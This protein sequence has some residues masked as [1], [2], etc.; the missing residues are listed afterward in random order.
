MTGNVFARSEDLV[1]ARRHDEAIQ[2]TNVRLLKRSGLPL[3]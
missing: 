1:F 2:R 3:G